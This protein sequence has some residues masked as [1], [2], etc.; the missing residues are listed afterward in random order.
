MMKRHKLAAHI[1]LLLVLLNCIAL[2]FIFAWI[3]I[4]KPLK[5]PQTPPSE[6]FRQY[7]LDPIPESVTNIR[8]DQPR[9]FRGYR[10]TFRF[11]INRDDLG[12]L[13]NSR[14]FVR[15]WNVKYRDGSLDWAWDRD[16]P[17]GT[18][19]YNSGMS[20]YDYTREPSWFRPGLWDNPE[21]YAFWKKG[22]LVN[23]E[24]FAKKSSGPT[25]IRVLLY[26]E[27]EGEAY[28]VVTSWER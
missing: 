16:G 6:V 5:T 24:R 10:Y 14:P 25:E 3:I 17:F 19:R 28:F 26:N 20:C 2:L 23:T 9:N 22:D 1:I 7:V 21:A 13:I 15:V 18:G 27:N 4:L 11:N 8:A 12:L